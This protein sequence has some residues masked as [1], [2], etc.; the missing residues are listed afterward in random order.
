MAAVGTLTYEFQ[1]TLPL[2][3]QFTF[4]AGVLVASAMP[5]FG[6]MLVVMPLVGA[7]SITFITVANT[8]LQLIAAPAMRGRVMALYSVAFMGS[9]P[10]GGPLV[11]VVGQAL[12]ARSAL[13]LGGVTA[14]GASML[15]WRSLNR[16][17]PELAP[18][19]M[20]IVSDPTVAG[21][22]VE[23]LG[24][25]RPNGEQYEGSTRPALTLA[26]VS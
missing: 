15:A 17:P 11:G 1:I 8:N 9:T 12:G 20:P 18:A 5:T 26:L 2:V 13:V 6:S 3:S 22:T 4:G 10:I 24:G 21:R 7:A 16:A 19:I 23:R 25:E 14:V